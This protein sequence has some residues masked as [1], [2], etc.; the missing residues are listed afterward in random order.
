M[1]VLTCPHCQQLMSTRLDRCPH[2]G[3]EA[4]KR[5]AAERVEAAPAVS[6]PVAEQPV[7]EQ[8]RIPEPARPVESASGREYAYGGGAG[9]GGGTRA[10]SD[11]RMMRVQMQQKSV[12]VACILT[13]V[14]GGLG[15]L[16]T[17][18]GW[19]LTAI[20]FEIIVVIV[21]IVAAAL[22]F[23][24]GFLLVIPFHVVCVIVTVI[25]VNRHN[26]RLLE[27]EFRP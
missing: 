2:C 4:E 10:D 24:L 3:R 20:L 11:M 5:E 6:P 7:A 14:F 8:P 21:A 23:G 9:G 18:I 27:K 16:Y 12:A 22:T 13:L 19:G 17:S 25:L 1:P 26:R 15:M